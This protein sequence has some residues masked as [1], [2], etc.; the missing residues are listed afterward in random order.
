MHDLRAGVLTQENL[1]SYTFQYDPAYNGPAVSLTMPIK[2][3]PYSFNGFPPF[4]DGLLPEG[5]QLDGLLKTYK[6]DR[7]DYFTQ[8]TAI[9]IDLVGAVTITPMAI[10]DE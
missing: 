3:H 7:L 2:D 4:F 5:I 10:G 9:G 8:L 1:T 6:I